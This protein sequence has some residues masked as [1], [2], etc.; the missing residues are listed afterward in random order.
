LYQ[1]WNFGIQNVS[2]KYV[3]IATVGDSIERRGIEHLHSV[4]E[5]FQ[6]DVVISNPRFI[7]E[8]GQAMPDET[9]PIAVILRR[10]NVTRPQL[11]TTAEQF[12]FVV[13]NLWGAILGSSA[14]NLYR[15]DCL[16]PRPFPTEFGTAGDGGWGIINIFDVKIAITPGRFSAFRFHAKAY[17]AAEYYVD[18]LPFKFLRL[19]QSVVAGKGPDNSAVARVLE[20]V[21]WSELEPALEIVPRQQARLEECRKQ[22][23]PWFFYPA[24]WQARSIRNKAEMRI[25]D[26]TDTVIAASRASGA[27]D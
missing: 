3:Y 5:Q 9:W 26:I 15:S 16:K 10:L 2:A 20:E 4:A 6:S 18:S 21:R 22:K 24:A 25:T 11:L 17:P 8:S 19:A 23:L 13:T 12:L 14:S 27:Q 1:S 7:S